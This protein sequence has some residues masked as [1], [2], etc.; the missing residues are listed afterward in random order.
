MHGL[1]NHMGL[2]WGPCLHR[3]LQPPQLCNLG[4]ACSLLASALWPIVAL[5]VPDHQLGTAYGPM[6]AIQNMAIAFINMGAGYIVDSCGYFWQ[7]NFFLFWLLFCLFCTVRIGIT[8]YINNWVRQH[9]HCIP[10]C[11]PSQTD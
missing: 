10:Q 9:G 7:M 3:L 4:V 1:E 5:S 6:Q 11:L 8:D 2:P